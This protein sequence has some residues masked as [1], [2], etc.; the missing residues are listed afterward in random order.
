MKQN[1]FFK[2]N[3][4]PCLHLLIINSKCSFMKIISFET[5]LSDHHHIIHAIFKT[6]LEQ[7]NQY[8]AISFSRIVTNLNWIFLIVCLL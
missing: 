5:S 7:I 3:G 2:S 4:G 6:K 1:T 8:T